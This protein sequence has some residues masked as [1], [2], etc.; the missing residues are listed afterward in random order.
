MP[1]VSTADA[2]LLALG[3]VYIPVI[4]FRSPQGSPS[5]SIH[6]SDPTGFDHEVR[7]TVRQRNLPAAILKNGS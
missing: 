5:P 3:T 6:A 1:D 7:H 2:T 4:V